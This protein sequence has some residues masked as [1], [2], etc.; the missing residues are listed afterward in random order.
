MINS[1]LEVTLPSLMQ[2]GNIPGAKD[3]LGSYNFYASPRAISKIEQSEFYPQLRQ[4]V[5]VR[6]FPLQKGFWETTSNTL[7]QMK[8]SAKE[9]HYMLIMA[10]DNAVGNESI[11]NMAKLCNGEHNPILFGFPRI[12]EDG[13]DEMKDLYANRAIISNRRLVNI[14]MKHI[15]QT[16]YPICHM[17]S[18]RI[19]HFNAWAVHHNVPTPC[20]LPDE[21]IIEI[22]STNRTRNGGFDHA[23]PFLMME[24][25]YPWH[26]I[27]HSDIYFHV[28]RGKHLINEG[29]GIDTKGWNAEKHFLEVEFFNKQEEIWQGI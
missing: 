28:E 16:T 21:K 18:H 4:A 14:T 27:R 8:L 12:D 15:E 17:P 25:N 13:W 6:W 9:G 19:I 7:F 11:N 2:P 29:I 26:L 3:L 20:I 5:E 10:P 24:L 22:F 1:F 23:M